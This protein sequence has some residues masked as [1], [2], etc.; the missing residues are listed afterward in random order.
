MTE[1]LVQYSTSTAFASDIIR[2]LSHSPFSHVDIILPGEGLL[3]VSGVDL[4]VK[5]LGGV[6]VRPFEAWPYLVKPKV[7]RLVV[8]DQIAI[9][10]VAAC[11]SQDGKP[12]DRGAL[13]GF[14]E[15]Q[16]Y[17]KPRNWRDPEQ[18][19][20]SQ[21]VVWA[22]EQGK[23]FPWPLAVMKNRVT[24]ADSLLIFNLFIENAGDFLT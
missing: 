1:L 9:D 8:A 2:R 15:D 7:A 13:W 5:D 22:A 20:C 18:W 12:F 6:R 21:L 23:M 10:T 3:G 17:E 19:F 4:S 11:R 16:A 14:L 24:P